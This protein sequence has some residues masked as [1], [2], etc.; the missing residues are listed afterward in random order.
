MKKYQKENFIKGWFIGNFEPSINKTKDFEIAYKKYREGDY[1]NKHH[2]KIAI[3]IT[4]IVSGIVEMNGIKYNNGDIIEIQF[5][6]STDFKALTNVETF[7]IKY[8][9]VNNDKYIN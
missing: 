9:C 3:E 8:P 1:E 7:V 4:F 6:E 2:H 5:G